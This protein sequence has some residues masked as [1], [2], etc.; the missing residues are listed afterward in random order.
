MIWENWFEFNADAED[1]GDAIALE[2]TLIFGV[3]IVAEEEVIEDFG[4][5]GC[6]D[7]KGKI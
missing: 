2:E 7:V 1:V 5:A 6:G 3:V 4:H